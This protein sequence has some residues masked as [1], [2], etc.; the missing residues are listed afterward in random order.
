[1]RQ[2]TQHGDLGQTSTINH[3][4]HYNA[5]PSGIECIQVAEHMSFNLGNALKYIWR[6][7][8]KGNALEDLKKAEWYIKREIARREAV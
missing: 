3:P 8:E 4:R 7:D 1:M 5:H 6:A 2:A